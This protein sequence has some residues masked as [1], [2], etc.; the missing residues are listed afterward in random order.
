MY[1]GYNRNVDPT[2]MSQ[3]HTRATRRLVSYKGPPFQS[4][5]FTVYRLYIPLSS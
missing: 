4:F 1:P 5:D 2:L 3:N